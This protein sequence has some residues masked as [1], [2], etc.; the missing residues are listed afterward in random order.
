MDGD[1]LDKVWSATLLSFVKEETSY[2]WE[3]AEM[4]EL[5]SQ[6]KKCLQF[7]EGEFEEHREKPSSA[8]VKDETRPQMARSVRQHDP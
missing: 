4:L 1:N 8:N 2:G 6:F 5:I 3:D 7:L